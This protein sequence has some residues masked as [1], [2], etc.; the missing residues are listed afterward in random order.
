MKLAPGQSILLKHTRERATVVKSLDSG[1]YLVET[2]L[3]NERFETSADE[4]ELVTAPATS[5][6]S[7]Q[8][9]A[10]AGDIRLYPETTGPAVQVAFLPVGEI[11]YNV[12]ILNHSTEVLVFAVR[13]LSGLGQQWSRHG[14]LG[15][16]RG[17]Q[18]GHLYRD[19]L[20]EGANIEI[21]VS[22]KGENGTDSKQD[23]RLNLKAKT[24]FKNVRKVDW[25]PEEITVID[26][27]AKAKLVRKPPKPVP[28]PPA[29]IGA[30]ALEPAV[31]K[32]EAKPLAYTVMAAAEFP[33]ELDLHIEKLV[34]DAT[35]L[36][37]EE[38]VQIQLDHVRR[39]L[40]RAIRLGIDEVFIIHGRGTGAL[41]TR[42]QQQLSLMGDIES[43]SNDYHPKYGFGATRVVLR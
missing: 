6:V 20:N 15:P 25:Y 37:N 9:Q 39:Y 30:P 10:Q 31:S 18:L 43:F 33:P 11:D 32:V 41:R 8:P 29:T 19:L 36:S 1:A 28:A 35:G 23:R 34:T 13:L 27:F 17:L 3:D 40:D 21:Q 4:V 22:R 12:A 14:I 26:V 16:T 5:S 7:A 2:A 38:I 24:F 42:V